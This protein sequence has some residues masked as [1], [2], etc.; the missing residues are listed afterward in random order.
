M[1]KLLRQFLDAKILFLVYLTK[2]AENYCT[3]Y[4]TVKY[5]FNNQT[6]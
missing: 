6:Y 2:Q 5:N 4:A 1:Q 3:I